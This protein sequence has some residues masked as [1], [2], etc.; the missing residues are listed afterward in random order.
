MTPVLLLLE[1]DDDVELLED[2]LVSFIFPK[3]G[4]RLMIPTILIV[5]DRVI[6]FQLHHLTL[7]EW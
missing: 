7:L 1:D 5:D 2:E 4:H 6:Q 3:G